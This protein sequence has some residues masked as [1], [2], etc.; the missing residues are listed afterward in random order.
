MAFY[1][2]GLKSSPLANTI[3][4]DSGAFETGTGV[5]ITV[6]LSGTLACTVA[7]EHRNAANDATLQAHTFIFG[8]NSPHCLHLANS[9][10]V[11]EGERLRLRLVQTSVGDVQGSMNI[12]G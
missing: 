2:E 5:D 3:L 12:S 4:A 7:F 8:A 11:G 10:I 9:F 1:T 6:L